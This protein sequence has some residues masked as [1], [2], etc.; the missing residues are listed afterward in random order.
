MNKKILLGK[1][2][3]E[4]AVKFLLEKGYQ[5]LAQNYRYKKGEIDII[6]QQDK[7]LIFVEVKTRTNADFGLPE[8][9]VNEKKAA[10]I[11]KTAENYIYEINWM[12]HIRF[13]IIAI[14]KNE[15]KIEILHLEDAFC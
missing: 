1:Q 13:D 3:E 5:I 2:G 11:L 4:M 15:N 6:A 7:T 8:E 12:T 10:L 9:A 14:L